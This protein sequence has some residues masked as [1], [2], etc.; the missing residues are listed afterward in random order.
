MQRSTT[1]RRD[2]FKASAAFG[3]G[4]WVVGSRAGLRGDTLNDR[5]NVAIIGVGGR[6]NAHVEGMPKAGGTIVALCD[7]DERQM[8]SARERHPDAKAYRDFRKMLDEIHKDIDAVAVAT[9]DH[10]HAVASVAAMKLGKHCYCEKPLTHNIHEARTLARVAGENRVASQM[11]NQGHSN[12]GARVTVESIRAGVI[13]PVKEVHAWTNRP[14]WP[15]GIEQRPEP[16]PVPSEVDWEAW[17]GPAQERPYSPAYHPFKWRGWWA[18]GTGALGDMACH[19][20][21]VPYWALELRDPATIEMIDN[22]GANAETG[23]NWSITEYHFPPRNGLAAC[24]LTWYEGGKKPPEELFEGVKVPD[25]GSLLIGEKGKA[26]IG[27]DYGSKFKLLPEKDFEGFTPPTPTLVRSPGHHKDFIEACRDPIGRPACSNFDYAGGLTETVLLGVLAQ[28]VGKKIEWDSAGMRAI[29]CSE[30][31]AII[32]P[33]YRKG[34]S[35]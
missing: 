33:E 30:A 5:V 25:G 26:F 17:L 23:P 20:L 31:D 13:G 12:D 32:K 2:F 16:Q 10:T 19:I 21:D 9:A 35:L 27:D 3:A 18:F 24:K 22:S 28:R 1:N 6:G 8:R 11:G 29:N 15:Q 7:V 14:I 34:W 4:L